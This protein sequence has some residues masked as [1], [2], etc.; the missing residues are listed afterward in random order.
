MKLK[1]CTK[2]VW[3][4]D[5][6]VGVIAVLRIA[7]SNQKHEISEL[8]D[9]FALPKQHESRLCISTALNNRKHIGVP[10]FKTALFAPVLLRGESLG[11]CF[12]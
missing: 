3:W 12:L 6:W 5:R 2:K 1:I 7:N 4:M 9:Q 8:Q 10:K 11:Q